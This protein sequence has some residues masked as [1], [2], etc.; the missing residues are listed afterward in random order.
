MKT[1]TEVLK[2]TRKK[3]CLGS[4]Y[5]DHA[6]KYKNVRMFQQ[7]I[8]RK[9]TFIYPSIGLPFFSQ[10]LTHDLL[11]SPAPNHPALCGTC[12]WIDR[13]SWP[14]CVT[15]NVV[16]DPFRK[17]QTSLWLMTALAIK[18]LCEERG[19]RCLLLLPLGVWAFPGKN[20]YSTRILNVPVAGQTWKSGAANADSIWPCCPLSQ[21]YT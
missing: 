21:P 13:C 9:T 19:Q 15:E 4:L 20:I 7:Q 8:G 5:S 16:P 2:S 12:N 3:G 18:L 6:L 11:S 17:S 1:G 14:P 10:V